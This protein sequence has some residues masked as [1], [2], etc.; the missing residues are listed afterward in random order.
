[1][2]FMLLLKQKS[3]PSSLMRKSYYI[4]IFSL[5]SCHIW[6]H[7][8]IQPFFNLGFPTVTH[9][10]F[11][12]NPRFLIRRSGDIKFCLSYP[13]SCRQYFYLCHQVKRISTRHTCIFLWKELW[14]L[15]LIHSL[16]IV[17]P[18][19]LITF[20]ICNYYFQGSIK[21]VSSAM[22]LSASFQATIKFK[23]PA[24]KRIAAINIP[25]PQNIFSL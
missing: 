2:T 21:L 16:F 20:I 17:T 7:L 6:R 15:H 5:R 1:M 24:T 18:L 9:N 13:S 8:N 22:T 23:I 12:S 3:T 4:N 10:S 25:P 19:K 11:S 14:L